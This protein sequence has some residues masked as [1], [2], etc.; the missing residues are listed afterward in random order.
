MSALNRSLHPAVNQYEVW[1]GPNG[2]PWAGT[3]MRLWT[4]E[5]I[6]RRVGTDGLI[7]TWTTGGF[8]EPV[9]GNF[10]MAAYSEDNG[11]SWSDAQVL[12]RHSYK[13]LFTTELFQPN[14]A[15]IHAFLQTY[16]LGVWMT[17]LNS[18]RAI[19]RDG[20]RTWEGPHSIPGNIQNVWVNSGIVHSSG[21]WILPVSWAEHCGSQWCP[22][23]IGRSPMEPWVGQAVQP[24]RE[25][26]WGAD[27]PLLYQ[28]G[29]QWA[30]ANHRYAAGVMISQDGGDSFQLR[31]YLR[32]PEARHFIEPK[33]VELSDGRLVLLSREKWKGGIWRSES[34]DG[35]ETWSPVELSGIPNPSSKFRL[36]KAKDGRIFLLH[37]PVAVESGAKWGRRSPLSLWVSDDDMR[38]WRVK[39]DLVSD[40]DHNLNYPDGFLDEER[41]EIHFA[42]EDAFSVYIARVS[43]NIK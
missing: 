13:G 23:S 36:L 16:D 42:W 9:H 34:R 6:L 22:P 10:T 27:L 41:Q 19:S 11:A 5:G 37:N 21:K 17:Q 43:M 24:H 12:F 38:T 3:G 18:F 31:G 25:L 33:V 14:P 7:C 39:V 4:R 2:Y 1:P 20:G 35:G 28:A 26:P 29:N 32:H 15:E 40:P 8:S 30:D